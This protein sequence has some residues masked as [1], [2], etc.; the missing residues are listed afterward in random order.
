MAT[1]LDGI[2]S[3]IPIPEGIDDW[4][5]SVSKKEWFRITR[6]LIQRAIFD[7]ENCHPFKEFR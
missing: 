4:L 5:R 6:E 1:I 3:N 2:C 7:I